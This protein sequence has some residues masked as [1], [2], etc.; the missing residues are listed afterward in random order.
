MATTGTVVAEAGAARYAVNR[1]AK[2]FA[3][4]SFFMATSTIGAET[5]AGNE[6]KVGNPLSRY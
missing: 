4:A 1:K 3:Q 6:P 5:R 2:P